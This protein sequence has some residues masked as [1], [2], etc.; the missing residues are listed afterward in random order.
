MA[1]VQFVVDQ[2]YNPE[3]QSSITSGT[4]LAA[5]ISM[6]KFIYGSSNPN[7]IDHIT[8]N[9]SDENRYKLAKQY[10]M[11]A[12]ALLSCRIKPFSRYRV[13]VAEGYYRITDKNRVYDV[14][15]ILY[16]RNKGRAVVYE[17]YGEDGNV[18]NIKAF[19]LA[20]HFSTHRYGGIMPAKTILCYDNFNPNG[21]L[22]SQVTLIMPE[23]QDGWNVRYSFTPNQVETKYNGNSLSTG[24]FI[25]VLEVP[26]DETVLYGV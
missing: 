8:E 24:E 23:V 15:S 2:Q 19:D 7:N 22:H 4:R 16:L 18:D 25:E 6:A 10:I 11:Q 20:L 12:T 5:G 9:I 17:I 13:K 21:K 3:W 14:D 26:R 1:G